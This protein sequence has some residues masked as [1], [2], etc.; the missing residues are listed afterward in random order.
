MGPSN[1]EV[2]CKNERIGGRFPPTP[3]GWRHKDRVFDP[4][5]MT[6]EFGDSARARAL[7]L[8]SKESN[9]L[10]G[11]QFF[12]GAKTP[13]NPK[14]GVEGF[15]FGFE[16]LGSQGFRVKGEGFWGP[17]YQGLDKKHFFCFSGPNG[18]Q[19][20]KKRKKSSIK[21]RCTPSPD[22][23]LSRHLLSRHLLHLPS[24]AVGHSA[25]PKGRDAKPCGRS[26]KWSQISTI[27]AKYEHE[28]I[29]QSFE[30]THPNAESGILRVS[31]PLN[32]DS[33][34]LR[35]CGHFIGKLG[36]LREGQIGAL[37]S[38]LNVRCWGPMEN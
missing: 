34:I 38:H 20:P 15:G 31:G 18:F 28:H 36:Q 24:K 27:T 22:P 19:R 10:P 26:M 35:V 5:R 8:G 12:L 14:V 16:V 1:I 21:G 9:Q 33:G 25:P 17:R 3:L 23:L 37:S 29:F 4:K 30:C 13:F 6:C 11:T 7:C 2:S 32:A